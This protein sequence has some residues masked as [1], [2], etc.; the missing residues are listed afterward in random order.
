[1]SETMLANNPKADIAGRLEMGRDLLLKDIAAMP[2]SM[3]SASPGGKA[4]T[5]FDLIFELAVVNSMVAGTIRGDS[6]ELTP[7]DGWITA[8]ADFCTKGQAVE[9]LSGSVDELLQ[10]L[11]GLPDA[12]LSADVDSPLGKM[13]VGRV[14]GIMAGHMMYHSGQLN[15]IQTLNGDDA[16]HWMEG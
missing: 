2:D 10:A 9:A 11:D 4:R 5:G 16:F 1:M 6:S 15:Y 14:L 12:G 3:L 13:P 8:P 7:P